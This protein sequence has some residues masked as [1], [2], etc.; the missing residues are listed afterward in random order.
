MKGPGGPGRFADSVARVERAQSQ[1]MLRKAHE[2][3]S[4][5]VF[6]NGVTME[7]F[8]DLYGDAIEKDAAN[9]AAH[10]EAFEREVQALAPQERTEHREAKLAA[11][12]FEGVVY[13]EVNQ[14]EWLGKG[15]VAVRT[16]PYDDIINGVDVVIE[17]DDPM[18]GRRHLALAVD[19][20]FG[21]WA[22]PKKFTRI[23]NE[24]DRGEAAQVK[25][26]ESASGKE[27][28]RNIPRT[29]V[30][31]ERK[32]VEELASLWLEKDAHKQKSDTLRSHPIQRMILAQVVQQ[33]DVFE[34]YALRSPNPTQGQRDIASS[35]KKARL[36]LE[37]V[38]DEKESLPLDMFRGDRVCEQIAACLDRAEAKIAKSKPERT[39]S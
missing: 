10:R 2:C 12:V 17:L 16:T 11:D 9:V 6:T 24:I 8:R 36:V 1:A 19:V 5:T 20:S 28:L 13:S 38:L 29:V 23:L 27:R 39:A 32:V 22:V 33:L 14:S 21:E 34:Q 18:G 15:V 7:S 35:C 4:Q 3:M 31:I 37:K 25:Y 30:G 26:F